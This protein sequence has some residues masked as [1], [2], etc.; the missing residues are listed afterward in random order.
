MKKIL[1][2]LLLCLVSISFLFAQEK[3]QI[4]FNTI[5]AEQNETIIAEISNYNRKTIYILD[6]ETA[7]D[8]MVLDSTVIST[9]GKFSFYIEKV[10]KHLS[11]FRKVNTE[12][13][14]KEFLQS[15]TLNITPELNLLSIEKIEI[16]GFNQMKGYEA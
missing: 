15:L 3:E 16:K 2:S 4:T 13:G 12:T 1:T 7:D 8:L 10:G 6:I 14:E 11:T 5:N 9:D